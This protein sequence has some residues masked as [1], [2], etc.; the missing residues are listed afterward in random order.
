MGHKLSPAGGWAVDAVMAESPAEE[1]GILQGER[2]LEIGEPHHA[3]ELCM[4]CIWCAAAVL[5]QVHNHV[6]AHRPDACSA[7][8]AGRRLFRKTAVPAAAA[9]QTLQTCSKGIIS[10]RKVPCRWLS[11]RRAE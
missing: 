2:I 3:G 9:L 5:R 7:M 11:S 6:A 10:T 4:S 8:P 1:A